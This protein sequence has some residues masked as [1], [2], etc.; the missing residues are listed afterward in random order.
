MIQ[1]ADILARDIID[2]VLESLGFC[3]LRLVK[4]LQEFYLIKPRFMKDDLT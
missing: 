2:K 1:Q 4:I 3:S